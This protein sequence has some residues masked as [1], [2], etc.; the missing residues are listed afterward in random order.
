MIN[1]RLTEIVEEIAEDLE[2]QAGLVLTDQQ[3]WA[4]QVNHQIVFK[5]SE[6]KPYIQ[7]VMDY[8]TDTDADD[9]VWDAYE[10]LS[11]QNYIIAFNLR[12]SYIDVNT[13]NLFI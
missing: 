8:L 6:F 7:K 2:L 4:L 5:S 13:L 3:R 12:S 11:T 10:V 9:R 1:I